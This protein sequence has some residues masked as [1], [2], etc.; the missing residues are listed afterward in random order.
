MNK[1]NFCFIIAPRTVYDSISTFVSRKI[2]AMTLQLTDSALRAAKT[3]KSEV[4]DYNDLD[5]RLY[6]AGKHCDGFEYGV[7]FDAKSADDEI[8]MIDDSVRIL[9]DLKTLEFVAGSVIDWIDDERGKG[10]I[11]SNPN[12]RKFRGKF[13]KKSEW[14]KKF[15]E[16]ASTTQSK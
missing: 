12:H 13:F 2:F 15:S 5:L 1:N 4:A 6:L 16:A 7:S 8:F 10:F 9:C 3:L 11:V 14:K